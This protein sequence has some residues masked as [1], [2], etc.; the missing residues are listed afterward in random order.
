MVLTMGADHPT[1]KFMGSPLHGPLTRALP[2]WLMLQHF[3]T[4][5]I[6]ATEERD[7]TLSCRSP[8]VPIEI[9]KGIELGACVA[10]GF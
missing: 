10:Q 3:G 2:L 6:M 4:A 8:N 9:Q 5:R 1:V 7:K